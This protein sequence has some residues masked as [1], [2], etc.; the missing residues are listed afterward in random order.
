MFNCHTLADEET[1][2]LVADFDIDCDAT[3]KSTYWFLSAVFAV[4]YIAG[5]PLLYVHWLTSIPLHELGTDEPLEDA[6]KKYGPLFADYEPQFWYWEIIEMFRKFFL[7]GVLQFL[8]PGSPSQIVVAICSTVVYQT[9]VSYFSPFAAELDDIVNTVAQLQLF[10]V[11]F[12]A[13]LVSVEFTDSD[14]LDKG[15]FDTVLLLIILLPFGGVI[16]LISWES[17]FADSYEMWGEATEEYFT[18]EGFSWMRFMR[19]P[20]FGDETLNENQEK[21]MTWAPSLAKYPDSPIWDELCKFNTV[22]MAKTRLREIAA[23]AA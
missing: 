16:L 12:A 14:G 8:N 13:L 3:F 2:F 19:N 22:G 5:T 18:V 17:C 6:E 9:A 4:V 1:S 15:L 7:C 20:E 11:A 10:F 23:A 21:L